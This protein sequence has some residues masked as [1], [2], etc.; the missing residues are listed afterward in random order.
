MSR[1]HPL[2]TH[3]TASRSPKPQSVSTYFIYYLI[4]RACS[5][6]HDA[7]LSVAIGWHLYRLTGDPFDLALVGLMQVTP[8]LAFFIVTGWVIDNFSRKKILMLCALAETAI[9]LSLAVVMHRPDINTHLI[10]ILLFAHGL[11]K[12][13]LSPAQS[14]L[15][16]NLVERE[17]LSKAVAITST[18]WN[19][20]STGGPFVAGILIAWLDI[21]TYWILSLL[22]LSATLALSRLPTLI[23]TKP[24]ERGLKQLFSGIRFITHSP[25]VL[26]SIT[27]DLFIILF[28][29][30]VT[31]LPIYTVEV[32]H[33]GPEAL[34]ILRG[35]PALGAVFVGIGIAKSAPFKH[36]GIALFSALTIFSLS[37]LLFAFSTS[38][39]LSL[40]AL[41][42]YG[43]TDM[44]S[45]NIRGT[46]LQ[47]ATPDALRGRVSA[48]NFIFI[49]SSNN[50]G[51]FRAGSVAALCSLLT[52]CTLDQ[53]CL[54][55]N[56]ESLAEVMRKRTVA[57]PSKPLK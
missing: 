1:Q 6:L 50:L 37:I 33:V 4:A 20:A 29:S 32:L 34:G 55:P 46:L 54:Y 38:L 35:M 10:F 15:L 19:V 57:Y 40:G 48:I 23:T 17:V 56:L 47:L 3:P 9:F 7:I 28:G 14:A 2:P 30:V 51:D 21:D 13:F 42:L 31:L 22:A 53:K 49:S 45:V 41:F 24:L 5:A 52:H 43:A 39:W 25:F 36:A 18:V 44:V 11:S 16:P 26:G 12:A 27:L 8:M